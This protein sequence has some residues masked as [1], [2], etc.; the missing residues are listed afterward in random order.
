M[1]EDDSI[2][3]TVAM[4]EVEAYEDVEIGES[5]GKAC[6][7]TIER[8]ED[9]TYLGGGDEVTP[10]TKEEQQQIWESIRK[11]N[12]AKQTHTPRTPRDHINEIYAKY[13]KLEQERR[14][15]IQ[16]KNYSMYGGLNGGIS[17]TI[18]KDIWLGD[19]GAPAHMT[20]SLEGMHKTRDYQGTV[21]VGGGEKLKVTIVGK[22]IGSVVQ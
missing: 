19:T 15:E 7:D 6:L 10:F 13:S 2:G 21:T 9:L 16:G 14:D 17:N 5:I 11:E 4:E 18:E 3:A 8:E 1:E 22:K 12:A 20:C